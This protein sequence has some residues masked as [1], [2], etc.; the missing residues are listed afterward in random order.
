MCGKYEEITA[1]L[2]AMCIYQIEGLLSE[3]R[4][5][6]KLSPAVLHQ[7]YLIRM[8]R[9][10]T[11]QLD[12]DAPQFFASAIAS[13]LPWETWTIHESLRR[14]L[15]LLMIIHQLLGAT[16]IVDPVYFEPLFSDHVSNRLLLPCHE[17]LWN[18][19]TQA[20][21]EEARK[22]LADG[23]R[24]CLGEAVTRLNAHADGRDTPMIGASL[25]RDDV[26]NYFEQLS[27]ITKLTISVAQIKVKAL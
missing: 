4:Y 25:E 24:G 19:N 27:E 23:E 16:K 10:I 18:A 20:E 26:L 17:S 2:H 14:V 7:E 15:F 8:T 1:A 6:S 9:R 3:N 12:R 22:G 11:K 13:N 21:W 5:D